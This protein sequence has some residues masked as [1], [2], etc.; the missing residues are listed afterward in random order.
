L[1]A[2]AAVC[3]TDT[4]R[5][6][7]V[8]PGIASLT[9]QALVQSTE[10]PDGEPRFTMLETV[11]EFGLGQL[12]SSG[13]D[14]AVR[15]A[16]AAYFLGL[17]EGADRAESES[18][19]IWFARL[20]AEHANLQAAHSWLASR[21]ESEALLRLVQALWW[22]W[23]LCGHVR[24]ARDWLERA[25]IESG[26]AS[27][28]IRARIRAMADDLAIIQGESTEERLVE[29]L[30]IA[31]ASGDRRAVAMALSNTGWWE[32][33][34]G[35]WEAARPH[36]EE[37]LALWRELD[38]PGWT[39]GSLLSLGFDAYH[40]G[41]LTEAQALLEESRVRSRACG[42]DWGV[43]Q[44]ARILGQLAHDRHDARRAA[45][46]YAEN[47]ALSQAQG[48]LISIAVVFWDWAELAAET[49]QGERAARLLGAAEALMEAAGAQREPHA[50]AN[51]GWSRTRAQLGAAAFDAA[52]IVG[53]ALPLEEAVA[54]ALA[55]IP[56][57]SGGAPVTG[58]GTAASAG[59]TPRESEVLRLLAAGRSNRAIAE[60]LS[61]SERTVDRHTSNIYAKL[62]LPSRTAAANYAHTHGLA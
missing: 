10:Q 26:A 50:E 9:D 36:H 62:G 30:G 47:L 60:T 39:A 45:S 28:G 14:A 55:V 58:R 41:A 46:M 2:A 23:R 54:E 37:A 35:R 6:V 13:E 11:R 4:D 5:C 20:E 12:E 31:R 52:W 17:A 57:A 25:L 8:L 19:A 40:L 43:A 51:A 59:L 49:G 27:P 53:R 1:P 21:G 32:Q 34:R 22:P 38:E 42:F 18:D 3:R 48:D 56:D 29:N 15:D 24:A 33:L 61:I 7:D 44:A 16:H